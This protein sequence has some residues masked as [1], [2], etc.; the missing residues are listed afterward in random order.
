MLQATNW[1]NHHFQSMNGTTL[2]CVAHI[3]YYTHDIVLICCYCASNFNYKPLAYTCTTSVCYGP[4]SQGCMY[5][6]ISDTI[7]K[8]NLENWELSLSV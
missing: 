8:L 2:H 5:N 6:R 3:L 4:G 7:Y 1:M